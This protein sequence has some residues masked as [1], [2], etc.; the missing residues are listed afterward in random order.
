MVCFLR[1]LAVKLKI[2]ILMLKKISSSLAPKKVINAIVT[3]YHQGKIADILARAPKILEQYPDTPSLYNILGVIHFHQGLKQEA[4]NYFRKTIDLLPNDPDAYNNLGN[5]CKDE[6]KYK[7]AILNYEKAIKIKP[8]YLKAYENLFL[9]FQTKKDTINSEKLIKK[10]FKILNTIPKK[11][12][13][14]WKNWVVMCLHEIAENYEIEKD[15]DK[16]KRTYKKAIQI[17]NDYIPSLNNLGNLLFKEGLNDEA[18]KY[19]KIAKKFNFKNTSILTNIALIFFKKK[20][21]FLSTKY[22]EKAI[23]QKQDSH[24][25]FCNLMFCYMNIFKNKEANKFLEILKNDWI[26]HSNY[27]NYIFTYLDQVLFSIVYSNYLNDDE[28]YK[29]Y[30]LYEKKFIKIKKF[31]WKPSHHI[32]KNKPKLKIGYVSPDFKNHSM[33]N[34]LKPVLK[35]HNQKKF[36]IYAFAE[37]TKED[38]VT[39]QYQSYVNHWIPTQNLTDQQMFQKIQDMEIDILV[40]LAGHTNGNRLGVF[41]RKPAP[42]SLC[43]CLGSAYTTGLSSIDYFLTNKVLAPN[44]SEHL[45]SEKLYYLSHFHA[46][47]DP[48]GNQMG[49]VGSL[50]AFEKGHITFGTVTRAIRINDSVIKVWAEIL[51]RVKNSKL[52]INSNDFSHYKTKRILI[53]KFNE[54]NI[55]RNR[56]KIGFQSPPWDTMRQI[57]IALDCFPHNSGT[58]LIEHL[59]MGNPFITYSNRIGVGK[60]G[61][62]I[63]T[64]LGR[65]EW[66]AYSEQEYVDKAVA[67]ATDK[68]KLTTIRSSLRKEMETSPIMDHK[69]FVIKLEQTYQSMWKDKIN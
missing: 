3:L 2:N 60:I 20:N 40:D 58:T 21:Y 24:Y 35:N 39:E 19:F 56:L 50:P 36:E 57:D 69:D 34:Y 14:I 61:A 8:N 64:A 17:K 25:L 22:L 46:I 6:K 49:D 37:L 30:Q 15:W 63:L 62:G 33:K 26:N 68:E 23:N 29:F 1:I 32:K 9:I 7:E 51:K 10:A 13:L 43:W 28:I 48:D 5:V 4:A 44:G 38:H 18:L 45:F 12:I 52:I 27:S 65:E 16:A 42:V 41:A 11:N 53:S 47:W 54:M 59:Y 31:D 67:L 66:I 55:D